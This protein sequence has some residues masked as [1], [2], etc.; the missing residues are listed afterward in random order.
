MGF[1]FHLAKNLW[2]HM[3]DYGLTKKENNLSVYISFQRLKALP[4]VPLHDVCQ[5]FELIK[6]KSPKE[7]SQMIDYFETNYVGKLKENSKSARNDPLF[8]F[9]FGTF[10]IELSQICRAL[11][12]HWSRGTRI[13]RYINFI[14]VKFV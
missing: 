14:I 6:S 12:M 10:M 9:N 3:K 11:I 7:F 8:A 1:W 5:A 4:F 2:K 13:L